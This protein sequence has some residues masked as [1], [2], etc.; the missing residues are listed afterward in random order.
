MISSSPLPI[1]FKFKIH[2]SNALPST[3]YIYKR[4]SAMSSGDE[5][6]VLPVASVNQA[7]Q[8]S[9]SL[10]FGSQDPTHFVPIQNQATETNNTNNTSENTTTNVP[11][12]EFDEFGVPKTVKHG[13]IAKPHKCC[14][15]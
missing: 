10:L 7:S 2:S 5:D 11:T 12:N 15:F 4:S 3:I 14:F 8:D 6:N 1:N 13:A 9:V